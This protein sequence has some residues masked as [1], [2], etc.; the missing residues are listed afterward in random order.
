MYPNDV[1]LPSCVWLFATPGARQASLSSTISQSLLNFMSIQLVMLSNHLILGCP[2]LFLPISKEYN[3]ILRLYLKKCVG[4]PGG[5]DSKE[6][7]FS[8]RDTGLKIPWRGNGNPLQ[9]SCLENS[10]DR[11]YWRATVHEV[12]K[13]RTRLSDSLFHFKE[14]CTHIRNTNWSLWEI[15]DGFF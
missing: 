7:A 5:S 1:Q 14:M 13:S 2:L 8:A 6:S 9:Y 10:M 12:A 11:G 15:L 4:F 3:Q